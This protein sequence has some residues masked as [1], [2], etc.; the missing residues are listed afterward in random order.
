MPYKLDFQGY[1][2]INKTGV[3]KYPGIY[4][5]YDSSCGNPTDIIYIGKTSRTID[6]RMSEHADDDGKIFEWVW[7]TEGRPLYFSAAKVESDSDI[8]R[9]EAAMVYQHQPSF[10]DQLKDCFSYSK[11]EVITSGKNHN[12]S[13]R[14]TV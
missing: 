7:R 11:T 8:E 12:L 1:W 9:L 10:N 4:C 13:P 6:V 5:V 3:A 14:F 2:R